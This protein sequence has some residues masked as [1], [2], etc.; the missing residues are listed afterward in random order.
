[1]AKN[2]P[3]KTQ[4]HNKLRKKMPKIF[5]LPNKMTLQL[6]PVM[7]VMKR[8]AQMTRPRKWVATQLRQLKSTQTSSKKKN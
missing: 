4:F 3:K 5:P 6:N 1:M 7:T 2:N 8:R